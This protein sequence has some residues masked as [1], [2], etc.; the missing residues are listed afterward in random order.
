[1]NV[2]ITEEAKKYIKKQKACYIIV[3]MI[4]EETSGG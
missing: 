2:N 3:H 4:P 1:M